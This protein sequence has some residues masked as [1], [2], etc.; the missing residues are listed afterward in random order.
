MPNGG[1]LKIV[2]ENVRL[3]GEAAEGS[4]QADENYVL[5]AVADTGVGMDEETQA[6]VFEPFF[7][8]KPG[9]RGTG[10]GLATVYG[11]VV[12][13][14]GHI[15]L[16]SAP[17]RGT[18]FYLYFPAR[19]G[20]NLE[21]PPAVASSRVPSRATILL[22]EDEPIVRRAALAILRRGGY[23]ILEA[24]NGSDAL[25]MVETHAGAI[26]LLLTDVIMPGMS[27]RDLALHLNALRP[28]TRVLYMSGYTANVIGQEGVIGA[29]VAFIQKPF[30][31]DALL[32]KVNEVLRAHSLAPEQPE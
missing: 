3:S 20:A 4:R 16:S 2:T 15:T 10:L 23:S 7:T 9:E 31:P 11:I 27:G 26:D 14:G 29:D 17:G 8:T 25:A 24:A 19:V 30:T 28:S 21:A 32:R 6:K 12:Q 22:V 18:T 5:V 1:R 13:S